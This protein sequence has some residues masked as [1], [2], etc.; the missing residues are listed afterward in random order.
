MREVRDNNKKIEEKMNE[1]MSES[2]AYAETVT[3]VKPSGN[4]ASKPDQNT[5][6]RA[7]MMKA[8]ND[9]LAHE[10]DKKLRSSNIILHG[11]LGAANNDKD[12]NKDQAASSYTEFWEPPTMTRMKNKDQATSSYTEFWEPPTMTRVKIKRWKKRM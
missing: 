12:E 2:R 9:E 7:I 5:D 3:N 8:R 11:V 6:F 1:V 10:S 4:C